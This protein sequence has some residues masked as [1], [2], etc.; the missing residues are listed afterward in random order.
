[1]SVGTPDIIFTDTCSEEKEDE[2][3]EVRR[4]NSGKASRASEVRKVRRNSSPY[5][6]QLPDTHQK[7]LE[8]FNIPRLNLKFAKQIQRIINEGT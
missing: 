1:M 8:K 4:A 3:L 2:I 6:Q 5:K 7:M